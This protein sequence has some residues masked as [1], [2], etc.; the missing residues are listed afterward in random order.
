MRDALRVIDKEIERFRDSAEK[1][2][3]AARNHRSNAD[4]RFAEAAIY[5]DS[6]ADLQR[7]R[8]A[9]VAVMG[10]VARE[11]R[12]ACYAQHNDGDCVWSGCPQLRDGEPKASGRH[13]PLDGQDEE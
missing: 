2:E 4:A 6:I 13:C 5:R 10:P 3:V 7:D 1:A 9:V 11:E 12:P 8:A